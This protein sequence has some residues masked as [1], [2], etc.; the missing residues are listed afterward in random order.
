MLRCSGAHW[1]ALG[2]CPDRR[3]QNIVYSVTTP[4]NLSRPPQLIPLKDK[5]Q[6]W[7]KWNICNNITPLLYERNQLLIMY[8]IALIAKQRHTS[9]RAKSFGY[10]FTLLWM[11]P[12]APCVTSMRSKKTLCLD[13]IRERPAAKWRHVSPARVCSCNI[14]RRSSA[15]NSSRN[16]LTRSLSRVSTASMH[17]VLLL[18]WSCGHNINHLNNRSYNWLKQW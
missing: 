14:R 12:L 10:S 11:L 6:Y 15:G 13:S 5:T 1:P 3:V 18:D 9:V 8:A 4:D 17:G 16:S 2:D 7:A